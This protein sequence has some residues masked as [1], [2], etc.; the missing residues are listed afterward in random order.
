MD[1]GDRAAAVLDVV[2]PESARTLL[3]TL[4][5]DVLD[6]AIQEGPDAVEA[7][8]LWSE[9]DLREHGVELALRA[10]KD[11]QVIADVRK[12]IELQPIDPK[13]LTTEQRS[14]IKSIADNST[15]YPDA[16]QIVLGKWVDQGGGFVETAKNT[17][18]THYNPH[19]KMW[20]RLGA[21]GVENQSEVAWLI[22]QQVVQTAIDKGLPIEYSLN[23]LGTKLTDNEH[24]AIDA[25]FSGKSDGEI[26]EKLDSDYI[27]IR[28]KELQ[29]L[30]IAGY[31]LSFDET[32]D[33]YILLPSQ[34][35]NLK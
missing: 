4:D 32:T 5:A 22:N 2:D 8:S 24:A 20:D 13:N 19:S 7:L 30:K 12:L 18:S 23:G 25:I 14:L 6:Y 15:Q 31:E 21:L 33:S 11:A 17:G 10:K 3:K 16:G 34:K 29:E 9:T 35:G 28:M 27:P 26:M 1:Y